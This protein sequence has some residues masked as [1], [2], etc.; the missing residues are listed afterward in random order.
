MH[1]LS[2]VIG[3]EK[4]NSIKDCVIGREDPSH[5]RRERTEV[6]AKELRIAREQCSVAAFAN[7]MHFVKPTEQIR[8]LLIIGLDLRQ[9][10]IHRSLYHLGRDIRSSPAFKPNPILSCRQH[11]PFAS[12]ENP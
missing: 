12:R 7:E 2:S 11:S 5:F 4:K 9:N 6:K 1:D 10:S 3:I 8:V